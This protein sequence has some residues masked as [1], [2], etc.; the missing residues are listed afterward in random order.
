MKAD[1]TKLLSQTD[2]TSKQIA[3]VFGIPDSYLN[4]QGDQQSNIDQ[5]KGMYTNALNRYLQAILAE[6]DNK[7][8]AKITANIRTAV[9]PLGDSFAATLSGLAKDGTIANNQATWVLQQTGYFPDE[10]PA[11]EK[12]PTQQVVIQSGKG[13]DNNDK[14]SDD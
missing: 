7:L 11:A 3:K 8:N 12:S 2:W 1:V 6:L 4:G 9:D 10:M 5:I 14:E 13:G